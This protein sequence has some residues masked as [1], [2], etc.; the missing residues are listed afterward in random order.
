[1]KVVVRPV[2]VVTLFITLAFAAGLAYALLDLD[3]SRMATLLPAQ[4]YLSRGME[5]TGAVNMVSAVLLDY[6][7]FDT[8]IEALVIF[9]AAWVISRLLS[10]TPAPACRPP[11]SPIVQC[12]LGYLGP[13]FWIFPVSIILRG[14]LSP[15]GGF[16]GGVALAVLLIL[17]RIVYGDRPAAP[18]IATPVLST[19]EILGALLF[20]AIGLIGLAGGE[21]FLANLAAGFRAGS[22][23]SLASAGSMFFL[24]IAI[25]CKVAAALALIHQR[26]ERGTGGG[27]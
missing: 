15:G 17:A 25:G 12:A 1:M 6:R 11:L 18:G 19:V 23:G 26:L 16:Q 10:K 5:D 24:N 7:G 9:S 3:A 20:L 22:P 13:L 2:Q 21:A 4:H 27:S 14:H 8:L